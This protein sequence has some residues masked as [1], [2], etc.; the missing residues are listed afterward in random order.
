MQE[1]VKQHANGWWHRFES[2]WLVSSSSS[3][4]SAKAW[5]DAIKGSLIPSL[6]SSV[7]VLSEPDGEGSWAFSGPSANAKCKWFHDNW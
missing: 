5:R 3:L 2:V 1:V 4:A 6:P 7:L